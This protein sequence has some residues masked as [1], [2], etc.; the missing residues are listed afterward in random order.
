MK[1]GSRVQKPEIKVPVL[2]GS[3]AFAILVVLRD[4]EL[5]G[6][7]WQPKLIRLVAYSSSAPSSCGFPKAT[8]ELDE[9]V[10]DYEAT[11]RSPLP[12]R[13]EGWK[14]V[15]GSGKALV[16]RIFASPAQRGLFQSIQLDGGFVLPPTAVEPVSVETLAAQLADILKESHH[17]LACIQKFSVSG[18]REDVQILVSLPFLRTLGIY[19]RIDILTQV[20][21]QLEVSEVWAFKWVQ[22][23]A[24]NPTYW[25]GFSESMVPL[26][27]ISGAEKHSNFRRRIMDRIQPLHPL[28]VAHIDHHAARPV[29]H[30]K[31]HSCHCFESQRLLQLQL[32][33]GAEREAPDPEQI[34][35]ASDFEEIVL[36]R[37]SELRRQGVEFAMST[38]TAWWGLGYVTVRYVFPPERSRVK[39][40]LS[41]WIEEV[42]VLVG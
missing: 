9:S 35:A 4:G 42:E 1:L 2:I 25:T 37:F 34:H 41:V 36:S 14:F 7:H 16:C 39:R 12:P 33:L 15:C 27:S 3:E 38:R 13:L 8:I 31:A 24:Q 22:V 18:G 32:I 10:T 29:R 26:Y 17:L 6:T 40:L 19:E 11:G 23:F 28:P 5:S 30:V 20:P 21:L